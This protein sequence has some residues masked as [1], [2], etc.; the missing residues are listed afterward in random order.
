MRLEYIQSFIVYYSMMISI[1]NIY[2]SVHPKN[3]APVSRFI[4]FFLK[5]KYQWIYPIFFRVD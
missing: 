3:Y 5:V 1:G 4:V 2:N